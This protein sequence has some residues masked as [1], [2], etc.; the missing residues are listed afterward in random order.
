MSQPQGEQYTCTP[1]Q[2]KFFSF[3]IFEDQKDR[4]GLTDLSYE[5]K[6]KISVATILNQ[7]GVGVPPGVCLPGPKILRLRWPGVTG[8]RPGVAPP[9]RVRV[10][11]SYPSAGPAIDEVK[12]R[13]LRDGKGLDLSGRQG[14][15]AGPAGA[16]R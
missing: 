8:G 13:R 5:K 15:R 16:A 1:F 6:R 2:E 3:K 7:G 11:S 10:I 12:V 4:G 9:G 14:V